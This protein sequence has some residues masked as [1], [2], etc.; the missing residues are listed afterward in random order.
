M[1]SGLRPHTHEETEGPPGPPGPPGP[2]GPGSIISHIFVSKKDLRYTSGQYIIFND[3]TRST[4][5]NIENLRYIY[6][7]IPIFFRLKFN[8]K[9][10]ITGDYPYEILRM[11]ICKKDVS[12]LDMKYGYGGGRVISDDIIV[13]MSDGDDITISIHDINDDIIILDGSFIIF[14]KIGVV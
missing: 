1:Y 6:S 12:I 8:I 10:N 7:G 13:S 5:F 2:D 9:Y 4:S 3:L 14:E 11:Q